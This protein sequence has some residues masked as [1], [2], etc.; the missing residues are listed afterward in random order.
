MSSAGD[1]D[2]SVAE[3]ANKLA[4]ANPALGGETATALA[5]PLTIAHLASMSADSGKGIINCSCGPD[6]ADRLS[7]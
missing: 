2:L 1:A 3:S 5:G 4:P 6:A 7:G